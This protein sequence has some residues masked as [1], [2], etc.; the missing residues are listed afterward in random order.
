[1]TPTPPTA[2][3]PPRIVAIS[4]SISA[5]SK[6]AAFVEHVAGRFEADLFDVTTIALRDIAPASYFSYPAEDPALL[7]AFSAIEEADGVVLAT[8]IYKAS[9]SG[10]LKSFLDLLP[11]FAFAGKVILPLATG[12]SLAHVLAM[13]YG[14]RPVVQS[15]GARQVVQSHFLPESAMTLEDGRVA[16][17]VEA[18]RGVAEAVHHFKCSILSAPADRLLGHPRPERV[19][20]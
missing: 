2:E 3:A 8:P 16:L 5:T 11:Q 18:E 6:T 7:A 14:L 12:G 10:L 9:F 19:S 15:M 13:D 17:S 1:M 20:A 4:S